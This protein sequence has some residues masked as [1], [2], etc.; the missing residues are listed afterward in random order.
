MAH[1]FIFPASFTPIIRMYR[2]PAARA[3]QH[4]GVFA[5]YESGDI[6]HQQKAGNP[7]SDSRNSKLVS[8]INPPL[9]MRMCE[10]CAAYCGRSGDDR[11]II[12]RQ[13]AAE[14]AEMKALFARMG[15]STASAP[16]SRAPASRPFYEDE[17]TYSVAREPTYSV[18]REPT[19]SVAPSRGVSRLVSTAA[20]GETHSSRPA[21]SRAAPAAHARVIEF[22]AT[23]VPVRARRAEVVTL[24]EVI[25]LSSDD[26]EEDDV[27]SVVVYLSA[28]GRKYH[29]KKGCSSAT[30]ESTLAVALGMDKTPCSKCK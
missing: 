1:T 2:I 23:T 29:M 13:Q 16:P 11:D 21:A 14:L 18:A 27:P 6:L 17:P 26:E 24:P 5:K 10:T 4:S 3:D 15:L 30:R 7:C 20:V 25:V 9:H 12:I 19:Y 28:T 8:V 22:E